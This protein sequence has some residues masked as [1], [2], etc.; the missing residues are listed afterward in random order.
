MP[1]CEV[2]IPEFEIIAD[3]IQR[4]YE[5]IRPILLSETTGKDR[6]EEL[7]IHRNSISNYLKRFGTDGMIG[8]ADQYRG[9]S[10]HP[11]WLSV[12]MKADILTLKNAN[13]NFSYREIACIVGRKHQREI[14]YKTVQNTLAE[15]QSVIIR[16]KKEL[17]EEQEHIIIRYRTYAEYAPI[18]VGRNRIIQLLESDWKKSTIGE[19]LQVTRTTIYKWR[20]R[21]DKDGI[22]G[23]YSRSTARITFESIVTP[24]DMALIF[25]LIENNPK[26][27]HYRV[28]MFL[29]GQGRIIGHTKIWQIIS[30]LREAEKKEKQIR[31]YHKKED[32]PQKGN[33]PH[34]CWFCDI[35]YLVKLNGKWVY[36]IMIIDGFSRRILAGDVFMGQDLSCVI[37]VIKQALIRYGRPL[38]VDR[39]GQIRLD[40]FVLYVNNELYGK[41]VDIYVYLEA[42]RIEYQEEVIV[43]YKC[44]CDPKQRKLVK[45]YSRGLIWWCE[46]RN[47]TPVLF[48]QRQYR[49][50]ALITRRT[51]KRS[52]K[53]ADDFQMTLPL[54]A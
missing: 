7:G 35:R 46:E 31:E 13:P 24:E 10:T 49:R 16:S 26:I 34:E 32:Y 48:S 52:S 43:E 41:R 4:R 2:D 11:N 44:K 15:A 45:V 47:V 9:P 18:V 21:F 29:N 22:L 6:A 30:L 17:I 1:K 50:V 53:L 12:E 3:E 54:A 19:V 39:Y 40:N 27:G 14:S 5:A 20:K 42:L 51:W 37:P 25:E 33:A 28:K 36:S 38:R 23:L 8:L